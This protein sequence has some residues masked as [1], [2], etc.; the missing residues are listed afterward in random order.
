[1]I[2]TYELPVNLPFSGNYPAKSGHRFKLYNDS[3]VNPDT[4]TGSEL[5]LA[6][7][8]VDMRCRKDQRQG[9]GF[10]NV[11]GDDPAYY[12]PSL[13]FISCRPP[14]TLYLTQLSTMA[15]K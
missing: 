11:T 7:R 3:S 15:W 2:S 13:S 14:G 9:P 5:F 12:I 8:N 6:S 1:M 4:L 10:L